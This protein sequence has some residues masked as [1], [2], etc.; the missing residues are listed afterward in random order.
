[1]RKAMAIVRLNQTIPIYRVQYFKIVTREFVDIDFTD[2]ISDREYSTLIELCRDI[3]NLAK[4]NGYKIEMT[5]EINQIP[6]I[7]IDKGTGTLSKYVFGK[8]S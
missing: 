1:M 7:L 6:N 8:N 4:V 3:I 5:G 2:L